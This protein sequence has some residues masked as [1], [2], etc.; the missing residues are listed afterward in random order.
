MSYRTALRAI[1]LGCLTILAVLS[2][3]F[4]AHSEQTLKVYHVG[5]SVTDTINY[6]GLNQLAESRGHLAASR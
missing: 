4:A 6:E 5:N 2:V 3:N 1:A